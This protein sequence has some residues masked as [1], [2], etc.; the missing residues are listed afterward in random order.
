M[1]RASSVLLGMSDESKAYRLYDPHSRKIVI[2][3][4][5]IFEENECWDWSVT[6]PSTPDILEWE[7]N[8]EEGA[9]PGLPVGCSGSQQNP[10]VG[11]PLGAATEEEGRQS[12]D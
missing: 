11:K 2:S 5:V 7:N 9:G 1:T 12:K 6:D 8:E 3:R 4:D 10:S